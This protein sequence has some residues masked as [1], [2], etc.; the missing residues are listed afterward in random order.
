MSTETL[1]APKQQAEQKVGS[2]RLTHEQLRQ[3]V[4]KL[5]L[6]LILMAQLS[7]RE[8]D[9]LFVPKPEVEDMPESEQ[10]ASS[11]D[12]LGLLSVAMQ[13][14]RQRE[15][16]MD[17]G[18][19]GMGPPE[20]RTS[21]PGYARPN[22]DTGFK[23]F[24]YDAY[25]SNFRAT[26]DMSGPRYYS[27]T[28]RQSDAPQ[29]K[30][31]FVPAPSM[32]EQPLGPELPNL[33]FNERIRPQN[34]GATATDIAAGDR[35]SEMYQR[36][37]WDSGWRGGEATPDQAKKAGRSMQRKYHPDLP[38]TSDADKEAIKVFNS[39]NARPT[40]PTQPGGG[41]STPTG[42]GGEA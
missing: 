5:A 20:T 1:T 37:L 42:A 17:F 32:A 23:P 30:P 24:T 21:R 14:Q 38:T 8:N 34:K 28:A 36:A 31:D 22:V 41:E 15:G 6:L 16:G 26:P 2:E 12:V 29:P 18:P 25:D 33:A 39:Q 9:H 27:D 19:G 11:G 7:S 35:A 3:E 13:M 10:K 4:A 40:T